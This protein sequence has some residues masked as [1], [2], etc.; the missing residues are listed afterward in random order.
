[1]FLNENFISFLTIL[2]NE[3]QENALK[4]SEIRVKICKKTSNLWKKFETF[5]NKNPL[6]NRIFDKIKNKAFFM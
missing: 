2:F 6:E 1:M 4:N 3:F 5:L